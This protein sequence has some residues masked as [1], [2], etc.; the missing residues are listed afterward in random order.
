[1][2]D[3]APARRSIKVEHKNLPRLYFRAYPVDLAARLKEW[4]RGPFPQG[5]ELLAL[6][7]RAAPAARWQTDLPATPDFESHTTWVTP[8]FAKPGSYV[9]VASAREDFSTRANRLLSVGL[10]VG[11]LVLLARPGR[12]QETDLVVLSGATGE[13]RPGVAVDLY[14]VDWSSGGSRHEAAATSGADGTVHFPAPAEPGAFFALA[15]SGQS[16][17]GGET[18]YLGGLPLQRTDEPQAATAAVIYTDR[19]VYRPLQKLFFKV[20]AF[21]GTARRGDFQPARRSPVTVTLRDLNGQIVGELQLATNDFGTA[22]G[23]FS[24]PAGRPLG[25]WRLDSSAQGSATVRVEEYK[26]P[27]FEATLKDPAEPLRLNRPAA[28]SGEARYYFGLPVTGGTARYRV[29]REPVWPWW[30]VGK[31]GFWWL[32]RQEAESVAAGTA[33]IASDGSFRIAFL[34]AADE[35]AAGAAKELTYRYRI[36]VEVTDDGG[37]T[38]ETERAFR[39][40]LSAVEAAIEPPSEL[41]RAG[42]RTAVTIRRTDLNGVARP[43][44]GSFRLVELVQP[45]RP[46]PPSE[47]PL[48]APPPGTPERH[49]TPG[50]LLRPRWEEAPPPLDLM[51]GWADGREV[52]RGAVSHGPSG[53]GEAALPA[54]APGAYRLRYETVDELGSRYDTF[55]D[56][57]V[58]GDGGTAL[59]VPLALVAEQ[60]TVPVGGK[61]RFLVH[62]GIPGQP[63]LLEVYRDGELRERRWLPRGQASSIWEVPIG[64]DDRGG[65]AVRLT[66]VTDHQLSSQ[67]VA[68]FVPWDDRELRVELSSFRDRIRPGTRETFRVTVETAESGKPPEAAAAEVLAYM[69][70]RS[71]DLFAPHVPPDPASFLPRRNGLPWSVASLGAQ[72]AGWLAQDGWAEVPSGPDLRGDLLKRIDSYGLGGPGG[73]MMFKSRGAPMAMAMPA[74]Q[75]MVAESADLQM[76]GGVPPPP[77]P[78]PPPGG[79]EA[80][81]APAPPELRSNFAETAFWQPHLL[82]DEAGRAAVEFTVP[83]SV[84]SWNV[85]VHAVTRSL[86]SGQATRQ[87]Q[88]VKDLMVRPYLPRFL[89]EGDRADL[90]VVVNNATDAPLSGELVFDVLDPETERSLLADFGLTPGLARRPFTVAGGGGVDLTFPV[91]APRRVGMVAFKVTAVAGAVSDGELRPLPVLPSRLHLAQSRFAALHGQ[92][93][94]TLRFD[95]LARGGDPTRIDERL[96]V[97]VDGQL[98][99]SALEALPFL[100]DYPYECTEQTLNRFLS[101]GIL[102]RLFDR[103][104][105]IARMAAELSKRDTPLPAWNADDPNRKMLLEETPW[106]AESRGEEKRPPGTP[107][108]ALLKV[109]DPQVSR[110]QRASSLDKLEKAQ[111]ADGSFPWWPGGPPSPYMTLYLMYGFAKASELGVEVP[112]PVVERGWGYLAGYFRQ[113]HARNLGTKKE[114]CFEFLTFLNYVA[115]S[116]PDP[117]WMGEALSARERKAILDASF[118][119]WREHSPY[120]KAMLALT[121]KRMGRADDARL[122]WESVM[123]SAKTT[124]DEGTFW[125]PEDRGWL[126]YNDSIETHAMALRT[127]M[128]VAPEDP[129]RHGLVQ[130]L[131]LNKKLNHWRSTRA[132]AEVLYALV[133]YLDKEGEIGAREE[134][135]VTAYPETASFVF[136][137]ERYTGKGNQLVIPGPAIDPAR[138]SAIEVAK[139]TPGLLFASATWH[140]STEELPQAERGDLFGV[141]RRYWKR[142]KTGEEVTLLPLAEGATLAPGDEVE[143]ELSIRSRAAAEYVHLRD[144]R[145]AGLEP[146]TE[147]SGYHWD[148][149]LVWYQETRDSATNFFFENLPAGEYTLRYRVRAQLAGAFRSGPAT[150]Q[151][152]YAPEFVAYSTGETLRIGS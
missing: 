123:D 67:E 41:L 132:T 131:F 7:Q 52:A 56:L 78:P 117:S 136:D 55:R 139:E 108:P 21:H 64:P 44:E 98:L 3:D 23:E 96:V 57:I 48:P 119:H 90:K 51:R 45:E 69:Y 5:E 106:L 124:A 24:I 39:L 144:P 28:F 47:Q 76:A 91:T 13:P 60:A 59:A 17:G 109:L 38:R 97:T 99:Y 14:R 103:Q 16:A 110:A 29:T 26:R 19:S 75:A 94:K 35:R 34:P 61:A 54:L 85:W 107:D 100:I 8:P 102:S 77:P 25:A 120:L 6:V 65:F 27:T 63:L 68:L 128:E 20:L 116:Y 74:P 82:T 33:P 115:S 88:S 89:R 80:E 42:E 129:R 111:L 152:M 134:V 46:L 50:D 140:F 112:R 127:L 30:W 10:T 37:E 95:D 146:G 101:T 32:P 138:S 70:D 15:Q 105:A 43:G 81:P 118:R 22:S 142:V 53:Q 121:L 40:G 137:P 135:E 18:S 73:R 9:V 36:S 151:S 58:A 12:P 4:R 114:C 113:E 122:V 93:R 62:S 143:V 66:A 31:G 71:L 92:E 84:T 133:H 87:T 86:Q 104:P 148:L 83:D 72:G 2:R 79:G 147:P 126:W 49:R 145:P 149:G 125:Q 1:M 11:D 130:W 150:L 141:S